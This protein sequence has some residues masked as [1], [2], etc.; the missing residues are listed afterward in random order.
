[1]GALRLLL[2]V[3]VVYSHSNLKGFGPFLGGGLAVNLFFI[4][5][6]FYMSLILN[7]KY[8]EKFVYYTNR[9]L[10]LYP[11]YALVLLISV[12]WYIFV[13]LYIAQRP[14]PF[15]TADAWK[16]MQLWQGIL[17]I[18][19]NITMVGTDIFNAFHW[20]SGTGFIFL[21]PIGSESSPDGAHWVGRLLWIGPAWSIGTEIWFYL[22]APYIVRRNIGTQAAALIGSFAL[23]HYLASWSG[24]AGQVFPANLWFFLVGSIGYKIY[25]GARLDIQRWQITVAAA[26]CSLILVGGS[27][28]VTPFWSTAMVI[29]FG[30]CVPVIF[31][32]TKSSNLDRMIGELSYPV[33]LVHVL[34]DHV[35]AVV[36]R[37]HSF[38]ATLT[39]SLIF[40]VM[41]VWLIERPVDRW[42]Q[43][44][45]SSQAE[46]ASFKL[47]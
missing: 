14:P 33:Y 24:P 36:L 21:H 1:M 40:A 5:S 27:L 32:A 20:K 31:N 26:T 4:V 22:L 19:S 28:A 29:A 2:A 11:V 46:V 43:R 35:L 15:W 34:I 18:F 23:H 10:R 17:I 9:F 13:W 45:L 41:V 12:T 42:R 25:V 6:G 8:R 39:A 16:Q 38:T 47:V 44:R 3:A 37:V 30:C 7:T